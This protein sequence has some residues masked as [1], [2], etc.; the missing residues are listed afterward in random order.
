M[1][2]N[3]TLDS[4]ELQRELKNYENDLAD[5]QNGEE[6]IVRIRADVELAGQAGNAL[7]ELIKDI[8]YVCNVFNKRYI[9]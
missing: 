2:E 8:K 6:E 3:L 9:F 7:D 1:E 4:N 5:I